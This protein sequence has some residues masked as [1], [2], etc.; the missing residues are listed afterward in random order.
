MSGELQR[1]GRRVDPEDRDV[2]GSLIA[3][4]EKISRRIKGK[5]PWIIAPRPFLSLVGQL[6]VLI[7]GKNR[8]AVMKTVSRIDK[9]TVGGNHDVRTEITSREPRWQG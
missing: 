6:P 5:A 1:T 9:S 4:V 7:Y 3:A 8:D 2:I